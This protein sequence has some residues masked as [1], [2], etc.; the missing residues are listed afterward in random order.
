MGGTPQ[1]GARRGGLSQSGAQCTGGGFGTPSL[2]IR[3]GGARCT[4]EWQRLLQLR[5]SCISSFHVQLPLHTARSPTQFD[6]V[7]LH[8]WGMRL[9]TTSRGAQPD[10]LL[11]EA[12][13][14]HGVSSSFMSKL[15]VHGCPSLSVHVK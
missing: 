7:C 12:P 4:R 10:L 5:V 9:S 8:V 11:A 13:S 3:L 2:G 15:Q 1:E 6:N 14:T